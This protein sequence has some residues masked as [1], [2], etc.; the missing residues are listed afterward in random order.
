[1]FVLS[2]ATSIPKGGEAEAS[3]S[4]G[5]TDAVLIRRA[6]VRTSASF[7]DCSGSACSAEGRSGHPETKN[8][9]SPEPEHIL[10]FHISSVEKPGS[11]W[12]RLFFSFAGTKSPTQGEKK[13]G[14]CRLKHDRVGHGNVEFSVL[15]C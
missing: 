15:I 11:S 5:P 10:C 8:F 9:T 3:V 2:L 1:M 13:T 4:S 12:Y 6:E 14:A 7:Q